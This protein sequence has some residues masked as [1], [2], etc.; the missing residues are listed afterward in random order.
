MP[1]PKSWYFVNAGGHKRQRT[2][3]QKS[4]ERYLLEEKS[5]AV[6][7][8]FTKNTINHIYPNT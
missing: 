2:T 4:M 7:N 1:Q 5:K 6:T 3:R 8:K